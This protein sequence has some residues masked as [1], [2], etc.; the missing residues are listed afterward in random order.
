VA[1]LVCAAPIDCVHS[2]L[3]LWDWRRRFSSS[4]EKE[5]R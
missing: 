2:S 1:V 3:K 5:V 4:K